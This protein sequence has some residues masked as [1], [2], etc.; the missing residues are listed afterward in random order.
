MNR[1]LYLTGFLLIFLVGCSDDDTG[2]V[3]NPEPGYAFYPAESG[4]FIVYQ[5]DSIYH[6]QPVSNEPGI[7]D[8][9]SF[10]LKEVIDGDFDDAIDEVSFEIKRF[11]KSTIEADWQLT[12]VWFAKRSSRNVERVEENQRFVKMAF[13]ILASAE[14]DGNALNDL[15]EWVYKYDSLF[16]SRSIDSLLFDRTIRID[17]RNFLTQVNDE[18][19]WEL[20]A[21]DVGLIYRYHKVLFT[22]PNYLNN[23]VAAN[24]ISGIEY[25]WKI[26][27][28]GFE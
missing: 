15:D 1:A 17:Q 6:D 13:P 12:D 10:F 22:R 26:I 14:W 3:T 4:R 27:N 16:E 2:Q 28:Y 8:T 18:L 21:E 9:V 7:H 11:K 19:A 25:R 5:V 24:I 23:R 20:Y